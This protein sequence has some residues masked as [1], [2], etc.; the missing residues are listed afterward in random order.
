M[1]ISDLLI[2]DRINLDVKSTNKVDIIKELARLH[3][4]TGVLNDY[5]GYVKA[6]MAREEQSSTGIGEGIAIPHAKTEFV[7]KPAL[8][9]GRKPEGIDYDSLDGEPATLFFM[10]A[11]PDGANNTHIETLARLSQLL[12]DD[13]FKEAL[14]NAKTADEVLEIINK[15][16]AEKFAEE[17]KKEA[18]PVQTSS[19]E[20]APYIIAATAC[21]T[22]IAHTYMAAEALKKAADEMGINIKVETNGADGRKNVLTDEDIKKATG[23]ILAINRNIEVDRF[24]GKPLIQVEAKEGINNAKALIQQV[25]DGKAPIFHASGSSTASSESASS[26]KKGLYK[27]LLSGVSYMLPLVISGGILIALAFLV[28]TLSGNGGAGAE[29]GSKAPLA[30]MLKDIGGQAFGL[31]VPVLAGYIA[32][33]ISERA[34]LAAGLVAGAIASAGGSGFIGALLGGFLAGYVVQ[35]LIKALAGMPRTLSGLKMILLYPV[36]SVLITGL[37]MVLLINPFAAIINNALNNWLNGM[38]G[39]SAVLLGA[40]LGGMMAIDMGGPVNKAAYVFGSG[41]LAATMTSGGSLPMA[42]VMAGGMVPPIAIALASTIFK[43][44]FTEQEREAGLTNYIMGFS[45]ITEGAIPYAAADPTRVI[46]AS[47]VGSAIA[48]ALTGLFNI[49]IPAPHGGILVMALSNNFFL[50]LVA[51]IIGSIVSAIVLGA[52][53]PAIKEG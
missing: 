51:V 18:V 28:D 14:E 37:G 46:P 23:V 40:V 26:E 20:N 39:S 12:L 35:G 32:Y 24:D 21:P 16:E 52:L 11:A 8:A 27:H 34:A 3:E 36:L 50:Y 4:K 30:K 47:V 5:D 43:N 13:D 9:M 53:K 22:G 1:K 38:S 19:D 6:L 29:Y 41:T 31:F 45:F 7:K 49:K 48:G 25:L 2:K 42:A 15:A 44:K 17:E 10:I 33:S